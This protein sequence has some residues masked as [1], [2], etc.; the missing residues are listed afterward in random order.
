MRPQLPRALSKPC[1]IGPLLPLLVILLGAAAS[2]P[3]LAQVT[4]QGPAKNFRIVDYYPT[5]PV[6]QTNRALRAVL[7]GAEAW[8]SPGGTVRI[9]GLHIENFRE[10]GRREAD[11]K[12]DECV[13]ELAARQ[14]TGASRL[15]VSGGGGLFAIEGEGFLWRQTNSL[16]ILSNRVV[17]TL[18]QGF[19]AGRSNDLTTSSF[20]TTNLIR[21]NSDRCV[22]DSQSNRVV[23]SGHVL[24]DDPQMQLTCGVLTVLF[25]PARRL[26]EIIAEDQVAILAKND[27]SRSTAGRA[28]YRLDQA[29]ESITLTESPVWRD[30]D[31]R[32]QIQAA[33]FLFDRLTRQIH[34][35]GGAVMRL[36]RGRFTQP[37]LGTTTAPP[38]QPLPA[39][40]TNQIQITSE[41]FLLSLATSNRPYRS[42]TANGNVVIL[43]PADDTRATGDRA[44]FHE[45]T[46]LIELDGHARW[47]AEGR[48]VTADRL[49]MDRT[50]QIFHGQGSTLF[51]MP[52]RPAGMGLAFR[53]VTNRVTATNLTLEVHSDQFT[54]HTNLLVFHGSP[55]QTH[56]HEG[57][58]L[59]GQVDCAVL[60]V[61]FTERLERILA[62]QHVLAETFPSPAPASRSITNSLSCESLDVSFSQ[63]GSTINL[64]ASNNVQAAQLELRPNRRQAVV[65]ELTCGQLTATFLPRA[66]RVDRLDAHDHV[67]I[68]QED[69][70]ARGGHAAYAD[71][72]GRVV[73]SDHPYAEFAQ[74]KVLDA[75]TLSWDRATGKC[76]GTGRYRLQ[77]TGVLGS[78]NTP[79]LPFL[80]K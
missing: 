58:T 72:D 75:D 54:Y 79:H 1:R 8:P 60:S 20:P 76:R 21:I 26:Q 63:D 53:G 74:G 7:T 61:F 22:L 64:L 37:S 30:R 59:R 38:P 69:K 66:G 50:N 43:S 6:G 62:Q 3:L 36:A 14:A 10:D 35:D 5:I 73:L 29:A 13:Y 41:S 17:T 9:H 44:R 15:Q 19:L 80:N 57:P 2:P 42:A 16:L 51:R 34:G 68:A 67:V 55:V 4:L 12:A 11:V 32:Q 78:T 48:L 77:W 49:S 33:R 52:L 25:T 71:H 56:L 27:Q 46:G 45:E 31:G 70:L 39:T 18:D 47:E 23:H 65:T 40:D 24:A 28:V